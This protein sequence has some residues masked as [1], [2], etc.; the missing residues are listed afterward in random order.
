MHLS[1]RLNC[2]WNVRGRWEFELRLA[3]CNR[4]VSH[5]LTN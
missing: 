1:Y 2:I 4:S 3:D 5:N